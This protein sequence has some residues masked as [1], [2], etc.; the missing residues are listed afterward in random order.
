M[1]VLG[2]IGLFILENIWIKKR[3]DTLPKGIIIL[4]YILSFL[5][6]LGAGGFIL[7]IWSFDLENYLSTTWTDLVSVLNASIGRI[8]S[9]A[10][11]IFIAMLILRISKI[12]LKRIGQKKDLTKEERKLFHV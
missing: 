3:E 4:S 5:L 1:T 7:F 10:I 2:L 12:T 9:S 11:I 6:L 8:I